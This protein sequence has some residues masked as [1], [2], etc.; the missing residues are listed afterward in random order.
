MHGS[1][2]PP[3]GGGCL[4]QEAVE[5]YGDPF[6]MLAR[7]V[8]VMQFVLFPAVALLVGAFVGLLARSVV[9]QAAALSL[10]PLLVFVLLASSWDLEGF[11]LSGV[12]LA[13]CCA[14]SLLLSRWRGKKAASRTAH[15]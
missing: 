5:K 2:N 11:V 9:W 4:Y 1:E 12:Y 15:V 6:D 7:G 14:A 3:S 13:L 8:R 10:V